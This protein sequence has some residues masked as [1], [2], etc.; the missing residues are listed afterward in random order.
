MSRGASDRAR[1]A[2]W[3]RFEYTGPWRGSATP[4]FQKLMWNGYATR[5][6]GIA[7]AVAVALWKEFEA[8]IQ[9]GTWVEVQLIPNRTSSQNG[10]EMIGFRPCDPPDSA[11]GDFTPSACPFCNTGKWVLGPARETTERPIEC[12]ECGARTTLGEWE[13]IRNERDSDAD[14]SPEYWIELGKQISS[15]NSRVP[16]LRNIQI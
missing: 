4:R 5:P 11:A 6:I 12:Q 16:D 15:G 2:G 13:R 1:E 10:M 3:D 9:P 14:H 8:E 7:P